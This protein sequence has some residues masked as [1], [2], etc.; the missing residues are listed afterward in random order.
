[1][2]TVIHMFRD[3]AD[4]GR[5]YRPGET[6]P[7]AGLEVSAERIDALATSNN[8]RGKPLIK[9]VEAPIEA[10]EPANDKPKPTRKRVKKDD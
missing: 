1:M 5:I 8:L 10:K 2:Y 9:F 3:N 4:D 7:R 6:Y